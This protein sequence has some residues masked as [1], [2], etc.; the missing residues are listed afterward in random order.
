MPT[1]KP[2]RGRTQKMPR[3]P[4]E[5]EH[6]LQVPLMRGCVLCLQI[7]Q[8]AGTTWTVGF[9]QDKVAYPVSQEVAEVLAHMAGNRVPAGWARR[10]LAPEEIKVLE[11][12]EQECRHCL[13]QQQIQELMAS[14]SS[15]QQFVSDMGELWDAKHDQ[16]LDLSGRLNTMINSCNVPVM[17]AIFALLV[18]AMMGASTVGAGGP[19]MASLILKM[20]EQIKL[21]VTKVPMPVMPSADG[22]N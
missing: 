9:P 21:N 15:V 3:S 14:H 16:L 1:K 20:A 17:D 10:H 5:V 22:S 11:E 7:N 4:R 6:V 12:R 19:H 8:V 18:T 13:S 2:S